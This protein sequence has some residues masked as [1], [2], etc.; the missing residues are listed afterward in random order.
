MVD[1]K[2]GNPQL[3]SAS[4]AAFANKFQM[5]SEDMKAIQ[6]L[7]KQ[8]P[9]KNKAAEEKKIADAKIAAEKRALEEKKLA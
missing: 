9:N 1:K 5:S 2:L 8:P 6:G 3:S 7:S 4:L